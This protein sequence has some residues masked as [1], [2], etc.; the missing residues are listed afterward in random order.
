MGMKKYILQR[1]IFTVFV[2]FG[3]SIMVFFITHFIGN[4]VDMLL[5][6]NAT[7]EQKLD[8][9]QKL[10]LDKPVI[11]QLGN[12]LMNIVKIDFGTSWWKNVNC[13]KLIFTT[14]PVT[15]RLVSCAM[16]LAC[17]I[18]I[19]LGILAAYKPGSI[20]DRFLSIFSMLGVCLPAFWIGLMLMLV[21]AVQLGWF[22]TSGM[23]GFRFMV[24]PVVTLAFCPT[25]HLAQIVRFEMIQQLNSLYAITARSKGVSERKVL[26]KHAF[27]N[28]MTAV[29]TMV[30]A[31]FIDLMAGASATVETV[32]GW[33]G[34]GKMMS[35]TISNMDFPL[36]QAEVFFVSVMV[37]LI[38][39]LVDILYATFDP[40]I[41]Y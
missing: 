26:F 11:V 21:F 6:L 10:G 33:A 30:G 36:L 37:C 27:K 16:I 38:N 35:D 2:I 18:A 25:A 23:G 7:P 31:D 13:V 4:P 9:T 29:L 39:L 14:L 19:P 17:L 28:I 34:F 20:L 32:Y 1:L 8:M 15:F 12:Y 5:P 41:R 22:H 40:R 24:L 3:I